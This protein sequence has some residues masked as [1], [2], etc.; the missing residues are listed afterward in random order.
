MINR[1]K[2]AL[3]KTN[4]TL[5]LMFYASAQL[6]ICKTS[7][8]KTQNYPRTVRRAMTLSSRKYESRICLVLAFRSR[9]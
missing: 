5:C 2:L 8:A 3:L 6:Q 9:K 4:K 1:F 7:A